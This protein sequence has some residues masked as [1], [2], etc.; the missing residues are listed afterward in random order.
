MMEYYPDYVNNFKFRSF[1]NYLD[2]II[3]TNKV[4]I[5]KCFMLISKYNDLSSKLI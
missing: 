1:L 4:L 3:I 5:I 2:P